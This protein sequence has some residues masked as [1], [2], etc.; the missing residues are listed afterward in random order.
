M[1]GRAKFII[2]QRDFSGGEVDSDAKRRDDEPMVRAACRQFSNMLVHTSGAA[3]YRPGRRALFHERGRVDEV[4][5][6]SSTVYKLCFGPGTLK[7]RDSTDAIVAGSAGMPWTDGN[8]HLI[9]WAFVNNDVTICYLGYK[10]VVARWSGSAWTIQPFAFA[11]GVDGIAKVPFYRVAKRGITMTPSDVTGTVNI[12]FS[13]SVLTADHVG[14][15]IKWANKRMEVATVTSGTAGTGTWL[16]TALPVQRLTVTAS[17]A[18]GFAVDQS[19]TGSVTETEGVVVEIDDANNYVYVQLLNYRSGFTTSDTLVGPFQRTA[20]TTVASSTARATTVW[21]EQ[22]FGD[23]YGWPQS[24][25]ADVSRLIFCDIPSLPEAICWSATGLPDDFDVTDEATGAIV[26][27]MT[28]KPRIYHVLG[29]ADEFVFTSRGVFYIPISESNPLA[30]GSVTFRRITTDAASVV[31]PA[32][33]AEGI[34]YINAG[35]GRVIGIR[36]TG[37]TALPYVADDLAEWHSHLLSSPIAIAATTGDGD[38]PERY[39]VVVNNDGTLAMGRYN[40]R[41]RWWGWWPWTAAED[42]DFKWVSTRIGSGTTLFCVRYTINGEEV[43]LVETLDETAYLDAEVEINDVP[44]AL[45]AQTEDDLA[46]YPFAGTAIG[47]MDEAGGHDALTDGDT[48]KTA[49][50]GARQTGTSGFYGRQLPEPLQVRR[51]SVWATSDSGFTGAAGNV[52]IELKGSNTAPNADGSN[53]TSLG[54]IT[55]ADSLSGFAQVASSDTDTAYEYIWVRLSRAA[56]TTIHLAL[57]TFDYPGAVLE[58][59][60]GGTGDLW[61]FAGGNVEVMDGLYSYGERAV[62]TDGSLTLEEGDS[63]GG[64][65]VVAGFVYT[66]KIEPFLPHA[67]EGQSAGQTVH[68]R[69]VY[70]GA[71]AVQES[72]GF[73]VQLVGGGS[74]TRIARYRQGEN[75]GAAPTQRE[76][77]AIFNVKGSEYDPRVELVK[78][79]AGTLTVPEISFEISV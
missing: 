58:A 5:V 9:T 43:D 48:T 36:P 77:T 50:Q 55:I 71:I 31:R 46:Y 53:G 27:L 61:F 54:S 2:R 21:E 20:I 38:F 6:D 30:P 33:S 37:Q 39:L 75:Q 41:K 63:L 14:S 4:A 32:E 1:A 29:G 40:P 45:Q 60:S 52:T 66:G 79:T 42:G 69:A 26:E 15:L 49:A 51:V 72:T 3:E 67:N 73:D 18:A 68:P 76:E 25:T 70:Q 44:A 62:D 28:G 34:A 47:D 74:L 24:C 11:E 35:G 16:E 56:A 78:N 17:T 57:V 13:E 64:A 59:P 7:I 22:V 19:V 65:T 23:A 10:P 8:T 12:T